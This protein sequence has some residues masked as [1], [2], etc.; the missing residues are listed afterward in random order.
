MKNRSISASMV[1][2]NKEHYYVEKERYPHELYFTRESFIRKY[3]EKLALILE[4]GETYVSPTNN[5]QL[6]FD[7]DDGK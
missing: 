5:W 4:S 6:S 3:G 7:F 2:P 1:W